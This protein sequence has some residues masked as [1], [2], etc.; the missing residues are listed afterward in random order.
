V[1]LATHA[2][3]FARVTEEKTPS[4]STITVYVAGCL[5][6]LR[7]LI[8]VMIILFSLLG[9]KA[10]GDKH[11]QHEHGAC[12]LGAQGLGLSGSFELPRFVD[13]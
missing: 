3:A 1:Y 2:R 11:R 9:L 6:Y 7:L 13:V 10:S 4:P 5:P 12:S 8:S